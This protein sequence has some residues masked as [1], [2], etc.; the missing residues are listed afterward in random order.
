APGSY[1]ETV[2][3]DVGAHIPSLDER[4]DLVLSRYV[5]EH[6]KSMSAAMENV[7]RYLKPGGTMVSIIPGAWAAFAVLN[8]VLPRRVSRGLMHML[9]G[10]PA[11]TVFPAYYDR[12]S[13][14]AL[15]DTMASWTTSEV[16]PTFC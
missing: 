4:F 7:R 13:F 1:D 6:V 16:V 15:Q 8:R 9:H 14:S 2:V 12:C 11:D 3:T 10:R 5:L